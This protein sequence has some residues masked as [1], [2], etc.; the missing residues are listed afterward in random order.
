MT[1]ACPAEL[2]ARG[3]ESSAIRSAEQHALLC[4]R[5]AVGPARIG[6]P[7]QKPRH[8]QGSAHSEVP[9]EVMVGGCPNKLVRCRAESSTL[10]P[11][12]RPALLSER[13]AAGPAR[14]G[15]LLRSGSSG[16]GNRSGSAVKGHEPFRG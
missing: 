6:L 4:E 10:R 14:T 7:V 9:R 1:S 2:I 13:I 5:I 16:D 11:A 12:E 15:S 8:A 3:P